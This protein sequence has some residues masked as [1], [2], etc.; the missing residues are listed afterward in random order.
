M[1]HG[2][3]DL[4]TVDRVGLACD[5]GQFHIDPWGAAE[6]AVITH[7]HGDHARWGSGRYVCAEA[8]VPLLTRRLAPGSVVQG[9]P[10]GEKIR[11]GEALVSFHPAGHVMGSAQVRVERGDQVWVASGDYK[12]QPDRTCASFEVVKCDVFITEATFALPIYRWDET[13]LVAK[14]IG[15]W[16]R[17]NREAGRA[18]V[19]FGYALGKSQRVLGELRR[20]SETA[21]W[22]WMRE[23][24]VLLHGAMASMT[25][26]YRSAGAFML[27]TAAVVEEE[28]GKRGKRDRSYAGRLVLAPPSAAGSPWMRRFG[29]GEKFETGFASGWMRVRGVRRR[30]GYDR[31]FVMSDHADWHDLLRTIGETGARRVLVTHGAREALSKHLR[32]QDVDASVLATQYGDEEQE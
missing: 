5:P 9:I 13:A 4:L 28:T 11:M 16:W 19:L 8:S 15:E 6:T 1:A 31:G 26:A 27:E 24:P 18:S 17:G 20:L 32:E 22:E 23:E 30:R 29:A 10:Y 25:E 14:E 3:D 7:A 2:G 21:G 12:R